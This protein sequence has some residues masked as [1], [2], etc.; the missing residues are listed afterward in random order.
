M[1]TIIASS[2][3]VRAFSTAAFISFRCLGA[4]M[5]LVWSALL[6]CLVRVE[7]LKFWVPR[8]MA[9]ESFASIQTWQNIC[10]AEANVVGI[11]S[12]QM[13]HHWHRSRSCQHRGVLAF[14]MD[15]QAQ[16]IQNPRTWGHLGSIQGL[17]VTWK[18]FSFG[19]C[20]SHEAFSSGAS[21]D[22]EK[23]QWFFGESKSKVTS[24]QNGS[25]MWPES[26]LR[27]TKQVS[28]FTKGAPSGTTVY[29]KIGGVDMKYQSAAPNEDAPNRGRRRFFLRPIV[30]LCAN[31]ANAHLKLI[32]ATRSCFIQ[33][34][35]IT[36][37]VIKV[38][39]CTCMLMYLHRV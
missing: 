26:D 25:S 29:R 11:F 36:R 16:Q 5:A 24:R 22:T 34:C 9:L 39:H 14:P 37:C 3:L 38:L 12:S 10:A 13:I 33:I 7:V 1:A 27:A 28:A 6:I 8:V 17:V 15:F 21:S 31:G 19:L 4:W 23:S 20:L 32:P 35:V 30:V 18:L 2:S